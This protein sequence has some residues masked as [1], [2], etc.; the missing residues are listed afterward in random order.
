MWTGD[1]NNLTASVAAGH[2]YYRPVG[3][4]SGS[5][6]DSEFTTRNVVAA[7]CTVV[8]IAAR[9][10]NPGTGKSNTYGVLVNGTAPTG[11]PTCTI[12][13]PATGCSGA[14]GTATTVA[15]DEITLAINPVDTTGT[16]VKH[17]WAVTLACS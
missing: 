10:G 4:S 1:S 15:T 8:G 12:T 6:A 7:S 16:A 9:S 17:A 14:A 3:S 2:L 13:G 5:T 11:G